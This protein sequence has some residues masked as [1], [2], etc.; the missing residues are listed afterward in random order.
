MKQSKCIYCLEDK[1]ED[2]FNREHVIPQMMGTF[3]E[4]Q[5]L[6]NLQVCI[7]CNSYFSRELE[8]NISLDSIEALYRVRFGNKKISGGHILTKGRISY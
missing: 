5:V 8:N 4:N 3:E 7:E 6:N 1:P 2:E